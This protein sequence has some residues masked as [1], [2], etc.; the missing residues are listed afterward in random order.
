MPRSGLPKSL[1]KF[2]KTSVFLITLVVLA[3]S[4][5]GISKLWR[6]FEEPRADAQVTWTSS[7]VASSTGTVT[8]TSRTPL[9][10]AAVFVETQDE[11]AIRAYETGKR[12]S[13][14]YAEWDR[15]PRHVTAPVKDARAAARVDLA[16][17]QAEGFSFRPSVGPY[18]TKVKVIDASGEEL[19]ISQIPPPGTPKQ[20]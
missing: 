7:G 11:S 14:L 8:N 20:R 15:Q 18:L 19:L 2:T 5:K 1:L 12:P 4:T 6:P 10:G 3:K 17:G 9:H 13:R 16:P